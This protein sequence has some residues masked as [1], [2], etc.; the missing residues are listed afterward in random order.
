ML[1]EERFGP[2]AQ[3]SVQTNILAQI[4]RAGAAS[5]TLDRVSRWAFTLETPFKAAVCRPI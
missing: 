3:K 4:F 2:I 5:G 1:L